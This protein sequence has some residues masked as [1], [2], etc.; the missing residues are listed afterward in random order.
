[1][2]DEQ[3]LDAAL[4]ASR[5]E[6]MSDDDRVGRARVSATRAR[7]SRHWPRRVAVAGIAG[8]VALGLGATAAARVGLPFADEHGGV[9]NTQAISNG[10]RCHQRFW[11]SPDGGADPAAVTAAKQ[12]L[13]TLDLNSLDL[14]DGLDAQ[15]DYEWAGA[16]PDP[17]HE[18]LK[19]S[20]DTRDTVALSMAISKAVEAELTARGYDSTTVGVEGEFTCDDMPKAT[21]GE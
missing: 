12:V 19:D 1:M 10:D 20:Q 2:M 4:D 5:P 3:S 6:V 14:S 7:T 15:R 11:I 13:E 8:G 16:G 21:D 18:Y 17:D 9:S